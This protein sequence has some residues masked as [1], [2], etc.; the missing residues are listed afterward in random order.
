[1]YWSHII[2]ILS[3]IFIFVMYM[4]QDNI[5]EGYDARFDNM[6]MVTCADFCKT[7]S[8]CYGFGYD[9]INKV[10]YPSETSVGG[11]P[12]DSLFKDEYSDN[13][14]VCNKFK[15]ITEANDTPAF[16]NRR[17]NAIY[18]C[19]ESPTDHPKY[20]Y[21]NKGKL[22]D[23]G[24]GKMIDQIIDVESYKVAPYLWPNDKFDYNQRDLLLKMLS[25]QNVL[26]SNVTNAESITEY[27]EPVVVHYVTGQTTNDKNIDFLE[28]DD[29]NNGAYLMDYK[30]IKDMNK[31]TCMKSCADNI[32]C[33][34]LEYNELY[35][36]N[37]NIC[38]L[39]HTIGDYAK[40]PDAKKNGKFYEK[41]VN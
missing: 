7:N 27:K 18:I 10:C 38:C 35:N 24:H 9:K 22:N 23:I 20:Y 29:I 36:D 40:R 31:E 2:L 19:T 3:M 39:Y 8:N 16:V 14:V 33:N 28:K 30:C 4:K 21:H 1:M 41:I 34:G 6:T 37:K 25:K 26:P 15:V 17:M 11:Y 5:I 12:K 13:N 32:N